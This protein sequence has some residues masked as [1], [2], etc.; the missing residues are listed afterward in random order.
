MKAHRVVV[1]QN[2]L[3]EDVVDADTI[4]PIKRHLERN[5]LGTGGYRSNEDKLN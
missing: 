1:F 4:T 5:N 2:V 3:T